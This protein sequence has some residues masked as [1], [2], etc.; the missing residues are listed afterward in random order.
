MAFL[1]YPPGSREVDLLQTAVLNVGQHSTRFGGE[2]PSKSARSGLRP[3]L[4]ST[5]LRALS[6]RFGPKGP[7]FSAFRLLPLRLSPSAHDEASLRE[8]GF[9]AR[10]EAKRRLG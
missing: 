7:R 10:G 2:R 4:V 9:Y 6:A 1:L 5:A 8:V 3:P